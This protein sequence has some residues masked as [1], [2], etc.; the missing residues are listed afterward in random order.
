MHDPRSSLASTR[1]RTEAPAGSEAHCLHTGFPLPRGLPGSGRSYVSSTSVLRLRTTPGDGGHKGRKMVG[2]ASK[3]RPST[4]PQASP[5]QL[6]CHSAYVCAE[7]TAILSEGGY[8]AYFPHT[9]CGRNS[10]V[11]PRGNH[12]IAHRISPGH[13]RACA[14]QSSAAPPR[15]R[16][17]IRWPMPAFKSRNPR[18][19]L[20]AGIPCGHAACRC[21]WSGRRDLNPR[22]FAWQANAL[23]L[24]YSR[25]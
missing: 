22:P 8:S 16:T 14:H 17:T 12:A 21:H 15:H 11:E 13:T 3:S 9:G 1:H 10:V 6:R 19:V 24:S 4:V 7:T 23:P 20:P 2:R 5:R 18:E 25:P